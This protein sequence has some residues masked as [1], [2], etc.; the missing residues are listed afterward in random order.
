MKDMTDRTN[1]VTPLVDIRVGEMTVH[2][3]LCAC[4][5]VY[6]PYLPSNCIVV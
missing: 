2:Y 4:M 3:W 1:C 6:L 5:I